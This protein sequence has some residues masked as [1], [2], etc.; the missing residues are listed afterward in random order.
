MSKSWPRFR[1]IIL[2]ELRQIQILKLSLNL[3]FVYY[4]TNLAER[5]F[6]TNYRH[7]KPSRIDNAYES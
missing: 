4:N 5:G 1:K 3:L 2:E 6:L 7:T